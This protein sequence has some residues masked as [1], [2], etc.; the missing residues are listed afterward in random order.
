M[1]VSRETAIKAGNE[2]YNF[3]IKQDVI[4]EWASAVE[5]GKSPGFDLININKGLFTY[6]LG[7]LPI[8]IK[9]PICL[10]FESSETCKKSFQLFSMLTDS[11][12]A[13]LNCKENNNGNVKSSGPIDEQIAT[14]QETL[15]LILS[16]KLRV[17]F[18]YKGFEDLAVSD[19][20]KNINTVYTLSVGGSIQFSTL[21]EKLVGMKYHRCDCVVS[22]GN[23]A[24]RG[25]IID[26]FPFGEKL[27]FKIDFDGNAVVSIKTFNPITQETIA[28]AAINT[29]KVFPTFVNTDDSDSTVTMSSLIVN[30]IALYINEKGGENLDVVSSHNKNSK[31]NNNSIDFSCSKLFPFNK[32]MELIKGVMSDKFEENIKM[33][34]IFIENEKQIETINNI[35]DFKVIY[36]KSPFFGG[37][38]SNVLNICCFSFDYIFSLP[39]KLNQR[40]VAAFSGEINKISLLSDIEINQPMVHENYGIGIYKGVSTINTS[41]G[42]RECIKIQ[43]LNSGNVYVPVENLC[44]VHKYIGQ[45]KPKINTLGSQM[46]HK[47]KLST[48]KS[49]AQLIESFARLYSD[50]MNEVG[51]SFTPNTWLHDTLDHTFSFTETID[52]IDVLNKIYSDMESSKP[53]DR[54]I[55]GDVGFGKTELAIR[56]SFKAVYDKK[57]VIIL[58]PT[59]VLA[60]QHFKTFSS[61]LDQLG[62]NIE[63]V[64]RSSSKSRKNSL[65]HD[66]ETGIIDVLIGTHRLLSKDIS[67]PNLGLLVI[68]EE[69][70]FG[71]RDKERLK[72]L[73]RSVDVLSMS[74]TP[75][76]RTLQSSLLKLRDVSLLNTPPR[77]RL[78]INTEIIK[79]KKDIIITCI[80][81]EMGRGGQVFYIHN[82]IKTI[83][84]EADLI[85]KMLPHCRALVTHGKMPNK[86]LEDRME[87]FI[88]S[89]YD[90]LVT[91]TIVGVGLD[92]TNVNTIIINNAQNF[93]LAQLHQLRGR[94]G[95]SNKQ[96]YCYLVIPETKKIPDDAKERLRLIKE[97][98]YLGA[99]YQLSIKDL[100]MRGPGSLF[101]LEQ[102]GH[103][104]SVGMHLYYKILEETSKQRNNG[105]NRDSPKIETKVKYHGDLYIP[106]WFENN[107]IS[108]IILYKELSDAA[109][110]NSI[111]KIKNKIK[112]RYGYLPI[113]VLNLVE[114]ATI[115]LLAQSLDIPNILIKEGLVEIMM[116]ENVNKSRLC[117]LTNRF[118][119]SLESSGYKYHFSTRNLAGPKL[120][121]SGLNKQQTLNIVKNLMFSFVE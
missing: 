60:S 75:I 95:R 56:A 116:P 67:V 20:V 115:K 28:D 35:I 74:A 76:P 110:I 1:A 27:P 100:E 83:E 68:D 103:I 53:M 3:L 25:S 54:L 64:I 48:K 55:C 117:S 41:W 14:L 78:S 99:G 16:N 52:Q 91:T 112:S 29:I 94:V 34:F 37:F 71:A 109:S 73:K 42:N 44:L 9:K 30:N 87:R 24:I 88:N 45:K 90:I 46:W 26:I 17:L 58:C 113:E 69:H 66:I 4:Y 8:K 47:A 23:F 7:V 86:Q 39:P 38:T 10:L 101:G 21:N 114:I 85:K 104:S 62:V 59:T 102:A 96:A 61:R 5:M 50:R 108:R 19:A 111:I 89:N 72:M 98:S 84:K 12:A 31:T 81:N 79:S 32:N 2:F 97:Y 70:L 43:Y 13:Y 107:D 80:Q 15:N 33:T 105:Q 93:G 11:G 77:R 106:K 49:T 63:L 92:I 36:I 82:D 22:P 18:T 6:L 57:Q 118:S 121:I 40:R 51:F 65:I 119:G 120:L